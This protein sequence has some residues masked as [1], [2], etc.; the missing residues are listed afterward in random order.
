MTPM[1][2]DTSIKFLDGTGAIKTTYKDGELV[3]MGLTQEGFQ[4]AHQI[5]TERQRRNTNR[6]LVVLTG[7]LTVLTIGLLAFEFVPIFIGG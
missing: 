2:W 1:E 6:I 7:I 5:K 4:M 3:N